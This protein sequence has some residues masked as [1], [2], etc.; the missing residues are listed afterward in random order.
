[1]SDSSFACDNCGK[2]FAMRPELLGKRVKCSGCGNVFVV[3]QQTCD[4]PASDVVTQRTE[5][6]QPGSSVPDV[7]A[8]RES[9]LFHM[10]WERGPTDRQFRVG[11]VVG[12]AMT[13]LGT[14][15]VLSF[16]RFGIKG[17]IILALGPFVVFYGF[18]ALVDPNIA[19]AVGKYGKHL[20]TRYKIIGGVI[21]L[22]ALAVSGGMSA[23][24]YFKHIN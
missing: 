6:T 4:F 23:W 16:E 24:L 15:L 2:T 18:A 21:G 13:I 17:L 8:A 5:M 22:A 1:M 11:S 20:P 9:S 10:D 14:L 19:R 7:E 12:I 3:E